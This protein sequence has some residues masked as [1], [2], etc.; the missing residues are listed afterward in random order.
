MRSSRI[1]HPLAGIAAIAAIAAIAG[2]PLHLSAEYLHALEEHLGGKATALPPE[3]V[4]LLREHTHWK[5]KPLHTSNKPHSAVKATLII[6]KQAILS[7]TTN[8]QLITP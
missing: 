6:P 2:H 7:L 3:L 5:S 4:L 1:W 8:T